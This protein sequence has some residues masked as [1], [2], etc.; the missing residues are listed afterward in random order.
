ME[1]IQCTPFNELHNSDELIQM[2]KKSIS[3]EIYFEN[4]ILNASL[5]DPNKAAEYSVNIINSDDSNICILWNN[6]VISG[7]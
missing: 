5:F 3:K 7:N 4:K 1:N 6:Y 2:T